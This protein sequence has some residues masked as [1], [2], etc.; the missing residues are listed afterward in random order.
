MSENES[1]KPP[2]A[3]EA[4]R[5]DSSPRT[6]VPAADEKLFA[7]LFDISP[8]PAVVSRIKDHTVIAINR[9]TSEL[10]GIPQ[11]QAAGLRVTDYY[12]DPADRVRL[13]ELISRDGRAENLRV[14]IQQP[15]GEA[16]WALFSARLVTYEGE[17]AILTVFT[18]INEQ[19]TA[20]RSEERRVGK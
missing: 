15:G 20:E 1:T 16:F 6:E 4:S 19:M 8:F 12:V 11:H 3:P 7:Q 9:R 14:Q 17:L 18:D 13:A 10:F 5:P 2:V